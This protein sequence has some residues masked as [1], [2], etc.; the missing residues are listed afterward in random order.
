MSFICSLKLK[1]CWF[2]LAIGTTSDGYTNY[3]TT[4]ND[5]TGSTSIC[6]CGLPYNRTD[7]PDVWLTANVTVPLI[8]LRVDNIRARLN[9]DIRAAGLVTLTA[10]VSV[11]ISAVQIQIKG[12]V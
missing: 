8:S 6:T 12:Q 11:S 7:P 5:N 1:I 4:N 3:V 9:L 2:N 10:G